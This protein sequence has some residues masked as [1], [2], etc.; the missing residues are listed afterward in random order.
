MGSRYLFFALPL[1]FGASCLFADSPKGER[2]F[3]A[4][5]ASVG[6]AVSP[7]GTNTVKVR[8]ENDKSEDNRAV[9]S[10]STG[11]RHFEA[12][13][14]FGLN[15]EILWSPDS[16]SFVVSG[17]DGGANGLYRAEV[18]FLG[19]GKLT[20]IPLS[21][22]IDKQ[23]GH[24]VKCGWPESPNVAAVKWIRPSTQAIIAAEIIN[25][26]NCDSFGTF[27]LYLVNV[28]QLRVLRTYNQ[29]EAK[30]LFALDLGQE[31]RSSPDN[32]VTEPTSCYVP[33]NH[34]NAK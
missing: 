8:L 14:G 12:I 24:P 25:H 11:G 6:Q 13:I 19:R 15:A 17:S 2:G 31:L 28:P 16:K 30:K 23:F 10:V 20:R 5:K 18:F 26:S 32:C 9:V 4:S 1:I 34:P 3:Y 7:D 21:A 22:F 29:I 33:T 27:R